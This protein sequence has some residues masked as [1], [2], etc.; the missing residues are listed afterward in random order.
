MI[1]ARLSPGAISESNSSHLPPSDGSKLAKP[2]TFP[3]GRSS[4]ATRP[5]ATGSPTFI[6]TIG[7]VR[8]SRWTAT[9][10]GVPFANSCASARIRLLSPRPHRRSIRANCPT[11][12]RKRLGERRELKLRQGIVFIDRHEHAN[13]PHAV[14]LLRPRHQ[15]PRHRTP[16]PRD[17]LPPSHPSCLRA[18]VRAAAYRD[19]G[20]LRT[21]RVW[22]RGEI[23][24]IFFAAREAGCGPQPRWRSPKLAAGY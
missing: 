8:V 10:A 4:R 12:V 2:V 17:E 23:P 1:A 9:V 18:A 24:S 13:A 16:E 15:R 7:M 22:P 19:H 6:K 20:Y 14:A 3:L 11:Q 5:L 21:G